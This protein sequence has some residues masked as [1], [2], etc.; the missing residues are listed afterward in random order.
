MEGQKLR[1]VRGDCDGRA[2][3]TGFEAMRATGHKCKTGGRL[4]SR[5]LV[6]WWRVRDSNPG[7]KDY[8]SSALTD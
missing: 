1:G 5:F 3:I 8:D 7:H 6:F 4:T 2:E